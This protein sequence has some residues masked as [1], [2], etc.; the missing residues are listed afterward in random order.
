MK[1]ISESLDE[2]LNEESKGEKKFK[3]VL[4]HWKEGKQHIGKSKKTVPKT[5][6]GQKQAIAIAF[7]EKKKAE[8]GK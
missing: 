6:E 4:H 1:L 8:K 2:F 3:K 5:P 7:S